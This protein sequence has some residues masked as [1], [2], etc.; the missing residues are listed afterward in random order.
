MRSID[1]SDIASLLQFHL[2]R[3]GCDPG[4]L[5]GAWNDKTMRAL[6][7]FNKNAK[8]N[9]DVKV[10][11]FGALEAVKQQKA[12]TC[13]LVC[14]NGFRAEQDSCVAIACKSGQT[15]NSNGH[16]VQELKATARSEVPKSSDSSGQIY[17]LQ[18]GRLPE[19]AQKLPRY[20]HRPLGGGKCPSVRLGY[21]QAASRRWNRLDYA[22][23]GRLHRSGC[24]PPRWHLSDMRDRV[25]LGHGGCTAVIQSGKF[26]GSNLATAFIFRGVAYRAKGETDRAIQDY[27][28]AISLEPNNATAF[29]NRCFARAAAG[30]QLDRA[31]EDCDKSLR[32]KPNDPYALDS[33]GLVRLKLGQFK[34]AEEDYSARLQSQPKSASSLYGRGW[35]RLKLNKIAEAESDFAAAKAIDPKIAETY[36]GFGVK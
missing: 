2:K 34:A 20:I 33:R 26:T 21:N 5:D 7:L 6:A 19:I 35:A 11:S 15:R 25:H 32:L 36:A 18:R 13:P 12:R 17:L 27:D 9:F 14:G 23:K 10:A 24:A 29:N 31:L 16:C 4:P 3:V 22:G 28:Q 1:A 30:R 8:T